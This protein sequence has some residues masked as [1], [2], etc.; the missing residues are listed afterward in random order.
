MSHS[1]HRMIRYCF[2]GGLAA[3][4]DLSIF[5]IFSLWMG[6]NYLV[7]AGAGFVVATAVNYW[8]C[9]RY[10]FESGARFGRHAEIT[11]IFMVSGVGLFMHEIFLFILHENFGIH[12]FIA[13]VAA[14]GMVFFW[15]FSARNFYVFAR[16]SNAE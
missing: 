11:G 13:K 6:Y 16:P 12:Q 14:I 10:I 15:N 7:V 3:I 2:A 5:A 9:I 8:L 1:L 4:V